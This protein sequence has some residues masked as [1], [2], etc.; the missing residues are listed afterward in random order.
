MPENPTLPGSTAEPPNKDVKTYFTEEII[1][2]IEGWS[3]CSKLYW[4]PSEPFKIVK[5][6]F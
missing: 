1:L 2:D 6:I 4:K 5:C 3:K